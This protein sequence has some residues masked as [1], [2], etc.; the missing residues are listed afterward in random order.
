MDGSKIYITATSAVNIT[1]ESMIRARGRKR[2]EETAGIVVVG[3]ITRLSVGSVKNKGL[4]PVL[5]STGEESR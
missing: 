3:L 5:C 1:A 4:F 2:R